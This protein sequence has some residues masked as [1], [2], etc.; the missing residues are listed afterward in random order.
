[1]S[2]KQLALIALAV[3]AL[4]RL[5][6]PSAPDFAVAIPSFGMMLSLIISRF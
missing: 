1:M 3:T 5:A 4:D 2:M 6:A